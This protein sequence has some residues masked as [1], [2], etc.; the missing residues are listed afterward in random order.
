MN[1]LAAEV[2]DEFAQA[3]AHGNDFLAHF[4]PDLLDHAHHVALLRRRLRS[5]NEVRAAQDVDVQGMV[6]HDEG[7]IDQFAN[8]PGGGRRLNLVKVIQRL[9]GGHVVRGGANPADATGDLGH[10]LGGPAQ[11]EDLETAQLGDLQ[12]GPLHIALLVQENVNL[13]VAF[14]AGNRVNRHPAPLRVGR[15]SGAR[16]RFIPNF[17]GFGV[18]GASLSGSTG[19]PTL[20]RNKLV[21]SP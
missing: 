20:R 16:R 9:G 19:R 13:A 8:L 2:S 10:L 12:V 6:L 4:D 15:R 17:A 18:H 3:A 11:A 14:Q 7:V 5:D 21:P 1:H